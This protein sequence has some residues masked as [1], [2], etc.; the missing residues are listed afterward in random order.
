MHPRRIHG[1]ALAALLLLAAA[2]PVRAQYLTRPERDWESIETAHFR[3]HFPAEMRSWVLPVAE[4]ME[5]YAA[6]VNA[7]VGNAPAARVTVMVEDPGNVSNGFA[8]PL[9]EAPVIFLWPTPPSP[10][11]GFGQHRGWGEVLA[12]HEYGHVAHLTIPSRNPAERLLWRLLPARVGPVA[13]KSPAWV[14]EGYATYLEGRLT[15]SGRPHSVGRAAVMRQWALEG[16]LPTYAQLDGATTYLGGSMRYLVGS[17]F[18][19]WLAERKGEASLDH[20]WRRMSARQRRSFAEAFRGVYG[21]GPDDLY[22]AFFTEVMAKALEG[23]RQLQAA[24]IVEGELVQKLAWGTGEPALSRDGERVAVVLRTPS[25]PSRL[26]I[27]SSHD[28]G[29]DS[30]S[31]GARARRVARML[32]RDPLDIAPFDSFPPPRRA[33]QVLYAVGGRG[34][35]NPRWFADN[36]RL[37]VSRDEPLGDGAVRPDLFIW[38]TRNGHVQR[39]THGA[40]IRWGDPSPDGTRAA[41]VRCDAGSCGLVLVDLGSGR[42]TPIAPG[43]PTV[44]WHRPRWSPDGRR[45]A[46]SVQRDGRWWTYVVDAA[47][48][49]ARPVDPGDGANRHSPSWTP[50]GTLVVVSERGGV[51][52]LELLDPESNVPRTLTRVLGSVA[53]P[54]VGPRGDIWYLALHAKGYDVR[55]LPLHQAL[56]NGAD[57][58]VALDARLAPAAVEPPDVGRSF[59]AHAVA[60]P[61]SYGAGPRAWRVLPG[62]SLGPDGDMVS[63]MAANVDPV[64]RLSVVAQGGVGSRGAWRG[65]SLA[66][67]LRLWPV[68]LEASGW[69]V[70]QAPSRQAA[71][72]LAAGDIDARL[73]GAGLAARFDRDRGG[74]RYSLRAGGSLARLDAGALAGASRAMGFAEMRA[75]VEW[76]RRGIV[77]RPQLRA[78]VAQGET[79]GDSWRRGWATVALALGGTPLPLRAEATIGAT[80]AADA[81][82]PGRAFEQFAVGGGDP[83]FLDGAYLGQRVAIPAVPVGLASGRRLGLVKLST[84]I[85]GAQPYAIW[86]AAGDSLTRF[87]RVL[88]VE[89]EWDVPTIGFARLPGVRARFGAGYSMD[90]PYRQKVR[91]YL[92]ITYRP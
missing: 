39:V 4:R 22:G 91:P 43:S 67:A 14:I 56:A 10:T 8:V 65:G 57:P 20:L 36:A 2:P 33:L 60:G 16:R 42:W 45:I 74:G 17:A 35:E 82:T 40:G 63:L 25:Q 41:A 23:R 78:Q 66:A 58:V 88:G 21:A 38:D 5:S 59:T 52:N 79:G 48:G 15:G 64:G 87:Q 72:R 89:R 11:P 31:A 73:S 24:G 84:R 77:A 19:E 3:L 9:L 30:A 46:A 50:E 26:A 13:R 51:A 69:H 34:H 29:R 70:E 71:G 85:A 76:S 86:V 47:T 7:M 28:D 44:T 32:E 27:W 90:A 55:R 54:D 92:G 49:S 80:T 37:L 83:P 6:A 62:A 18:L 53:A 75:A 61:Q 1:A 12:V 81:G 68:R